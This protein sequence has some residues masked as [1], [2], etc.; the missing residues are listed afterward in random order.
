MKQN[1]YRNYTDYLGKNQSFRKMCFV[2]LQMC[3]IC[4]IKKSY[5]QWLA[6]LRNLK[7]GNIQDDFHKLMLKIWK[8]MTKALKTKMT[9]FISLLPGKTYFL[10]FLQRKTIIKRKYQEGWPWLFNTACG[11]YLDVNIFLIR[12][13]KIT[14]TKI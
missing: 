10:N 1:P 2:F 5:F 7:S 11:V 9:F 6:L 14:D 8:V 12:K 13:C 4:D 3:G